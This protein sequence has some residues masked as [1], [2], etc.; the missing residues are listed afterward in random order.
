MPAAGLT[1]KV[2][3]I[4]HCPG[5]GQSQHCCISQKSLGK[6]VQGG[7]LPEPAEWQ[8]DFISVV[9][10]NTSLFLYSIALNLGTLKKSAKDDI[11]DELVCI[12]GYSVQIGNCSI[13]SFETVVVFEFLLMMIS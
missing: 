4:L 10:R 8:Q 6:R 2:Q 12:P 9:F 5:P 11:L 3:G 1:D 13:S 7:T